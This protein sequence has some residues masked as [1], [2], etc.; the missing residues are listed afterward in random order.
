MKDASKTSTL[1]FYGIVAVIIIISVI[2]LAGAFS[3]LNKPF[4]GFLLYRIGAVGSMGSR[5]WPGPQ[6]GLKVA[7]DRIASVDGQQVHNAQDVLKI[8]RQKT[9]G[10]TIRYAVESKGE[11]REVNVPVIT[12]DLKS[13]LAVFSVTFFVGLILFALGLVVYILKPNTKSS[14][15]FLALC[16]TSGTYLTTGFEMQSTYFTDWLNWLLTPLFPAV[17]FHLGLVFPEKKRFLNRY[18]AL[19]Y[20]IYIPALIIAAYYMGYI[21]IFEESLRL[22]K[23]SWIPAYEQVA[24]VT[25]IFTLFCIVGL[26][27]S[28][29]LT[30]FKASSIAARQRA[31]MILF[32]VA[33]AFLPPVTITVLVVFFKI[34]FPYN[35][36]SFF[37]LFFPASIAYSIVRHNLF[38]ADTIIR[39]TV[40][41][42]VVTAVVVGAYVGVSVLLNFFAGKYQLTQSKTFPILFTFGVILVFNPLRDRIQDLVDRIFFRKEYDYGAIVEKVSGAMTSMLELPQIL[43][44]LTKTFVDDMFIST[45]SVML[46]TPE[47]NQYQIYLAEGE[48]KEEVENRSLRRDEPVIEIIETEKMELTKYDVIEDPRYKDISGSSVANFE[49]L[50][51]SLIVPLVYQ[52]KVIGCLNL[53]EKKTGKPFNREDIDLLRTLAH[54]GAVAIEN[55]RMVD[56]IIEKERQRTKLMDSFGKYVTSE[57][58]DQILEGRIPMDGEVKDVTVLFADLRG[59]TT[60]TESTNP[61]EV[62]KIINGYFSE[63]AEAIGQNNGLVLQFIGDEIEAVFGAPSPLDDHPTHAVRAAMAMRERLVSVNDKLQKKGYAPLRHGIGIHTGNVVAANI[64]SEDRLSYAL[65]GD[66][67]NAASRIQSLNKEYNTDIL[68]SSITLNRQS[69]FIKGVKLGATTVKGKKEPLEIFKLS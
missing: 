22:G 44:Q 57:V 15:I 41:Y 43:Q 14:W 68:I 40:G 29:L 56:E 19:E 24:P 35:L 1:I 16:F 4:P 36:M 51:A 11:T 65:V 30:V 2:S 21:F 12:F 49:E 28:V 38:D 54:Q 69:E 31:R 10:T 48:E 20:A 45:S 7:M 58:R 55:A 13:F 26:V 42:A 9:P 8:I 52:D 6:A 33:I 5:D 27:V 25:R 47:G 32:G 66:T 18:P 63:M 17:W 37:I 39:R 53:G 3:W 60:L 50:R 64:G 46:M 23:Y 34:N 59:F 67:V 61:K 62:V